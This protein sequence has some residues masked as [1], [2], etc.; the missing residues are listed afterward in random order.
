MNFWA[1]GV[2]LEKQ[3]VDK[4]TVEPDWA[5]RVQFVVASLFVPVEFTFSSPGLEL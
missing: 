3:T 1:F 2:V 5:N 4:R